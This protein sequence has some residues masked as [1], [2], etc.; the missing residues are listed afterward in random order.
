MGSLEKNGG[1][2]TGSAMAQVRVSTAF[3]SQSCGR[4]G[5]ATSVSKFAT[6]L[7]YKIPRSGQRKRSVGDS[8]RTIAET[9]YTGNGG[10]GKGIF[11]QSFPGAQKIGEVEVGNRFISAKPISYSGDFRNGYFEKGKKGAQTWDVGNFYR[12]Q[13]CLSSYSHSKSLPNFSLFPSR[14]QEI[15]LYSPSVR[16]HDRPL[17][18]Y[19]SY[20]ANEEYGG[21][22]S[23]D[24]VS[25]SGRLAQSSP[26]L[27]NSPSEYPNVSRIM[28]FPWTIDKFGEIGTC[29]HSNYSFFG[30]DSKFETRSVFSN[31]RKNTTNNIG[32]SN[33]FESSWFTI[34]TSR[35][36][37]WSFNSNE[38]ISSNGT[39][40]LPIF[41]IAGYQGGKK[42]QESY[43]LDSS[44]G[45]Y[46]QIFKMVDNRLCAIH[47][48]PIHVSFPG[49]HSFHRCLSNGLGY[50]LPRG[51][52]AG[53]LATPESTHK[54]VRTEGSIVSHSIITV[55]SQKQDCVVSDRQH[56][57]SCI[58]P[59]TRGYEIKI[60]SNIN[61][62]NSSTCPQPKYNVTNATHNGPTK[63]VSRFSIAS[64]ADNSLG[65][66]SI[67]SGLS[68]GNA[69]VSMGSTSDRPICQQSEPSTSKICIPL[70]RYSGSRNKCTDLSVA[71]RG[72]VCLSS[73]VHSVAVSR[74]VEIGKTVSSSV[75]SPVV[76]TCKMGTVIE[77]PTNTPSNKVSVVSK[78]TLSTSLG[79]CVSKPTSPKSNTI[80]PRR[81]RMKLQGF[82][83]SVIERIDKSR[84]VS[85]KK[86]YNSQWNLFVSWAMERKFDPLSA[87]LPLLAE[88]L[89]YLFKIRKVSVRTIL[90]YK[91]A[92]AFYWKSEVNYNIPENNQVISDLIRGFK[93]DR[94]IPSKHVVEWDIGLVLKF[95][96]SG[97]FENWGQLS[98]RDLTLKS[99]FLFA[100]ATG[101]RRGELHALCRELK[102]VKGE[103]RKVQISPNPNFISK[104]HMATNGLGALKPIIISSLDEITGPNDTVERL[105]C[106]VRTL[107]YYLK[108]SDEYR[109]SEQRLLFISYQRGINKDICKQSISNYIKEAVVMVYNEQ[110][111]KSLK[112]EPLKIKPHSVRH[113]ATSL[114]ALKNFTMEDILKAGTWAT[115]NVFISHYVQYFS[116]DELSKLSRLGGFVAGN[117]VY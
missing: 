8:S 88:F 72:S 18:V 69:T 95:F 78:A 33:C 66:V 9:M 23:F 27:S 68:M 39:F 22:Q 55:S 109:S 14:E 50:I 96:Q 113:I 30:G 10:R 71:T 35:I 103:H 51:Y 64:R 93:R 54:L 85:T 76:T 5:D 73:S 70:P 111:V 4:K 99:V 97:R 94:P 41:S 117:A 82:S 40:T 56:D 107:R 67:S 24:T 86:H 52:V 17:G 32:S 60:T 42:R 19:S 49:N 45:Q 84:A 65:V 87:S 47:R 6:V 48:G 25:I 80:L 12:P 91:A 89:D 83:D 112:N 31:K 75:S 3:Q 2:Q 63:C 62:E 36:P 101:K 28:S 7:D 92:I 15:P 1:K 116:T 34:P 108:R 100:L 57:S 13:R 74:K 53:P 21:N 104:T 115:P 26:Y 43:P 81:E 46:S 59:E 38:S 98:D 20:Q 114:S 61:S 29:S 16:P 110:N 58:P 79:V 102:W 105:L 44:C 90:N 77:Q 106:P 11:L 37:P